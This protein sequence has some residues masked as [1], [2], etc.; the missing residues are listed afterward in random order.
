VI[1]PAFFAAAYLVDLLVGDP[2]W[3]P[4]PVRLMGS[5][6]MAGEA[7]LRKIFRS[8]PGELIAGALLALVVVGLSGAGT[9]LLLKLSASL[10]S[11][12]NAALA[13]YLAFTSLSTR[14][15]ID[16]ASKVGRLLR[17]GWLEAARAQV[18]RIVGRDT[19]RLD[20]PEIIR[21]AVETL[22]ESASDGIVAP[23]FYM[24]IGGVPAAIAYKAINTLD[25]MIGHDDLRHRYFGKFAARLDDVANLLPARLTAL[26]IVIAAFA[27]GRDWRAAWRIWRRDARK[28]RSPN[29][30]HPEAAMAG[31]LGVQLGGINFYDGEPVYCQK[32]GEPSKAL[33]LEALRGALMIVW[34]TSFLAALLALSCLLYQT[35]LS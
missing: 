13:I 29:A 14:D 1:E 26:L 15:L 9:H 10:S 8:G 32:M 18:G 28:H 17:M 11:G 30:G 21:A 35:A 3:L 27:C 23:I 7:A 31:A 25:S 4:H 19:D 24:A 20:E 16:E 6:I 33:D 12:L 22:A 34:L 5:A 2:G